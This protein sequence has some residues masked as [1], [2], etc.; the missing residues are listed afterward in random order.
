M[1]KRIDIPIRTTGSGKTRRDLK[2]VDRSIDNLST[3]VKGLA[4]AFISVQ[5]LNF[6]KNIAEQGERINTAVIALDNLTGSAEESAKFITKMGEAVRGT[7]TDLDLAIFASKALTLGFAATAT[8]AAELT[9]TAILLG[10]AM[11]KDAI[12]SLD[13]FTQLLAN[14]SIMVMDNLGISVAKYNALLKKFRDETGGAATEQAKLNAILEIA[15]EATEKQKNLLDT[16]DYA[17][18]TVAIKNLADSFSTKFIESISGSLIVITDFIEEITKVTDS[19]YRFGKAALLI[20]SILFVG[21]GLILGFKLLTVGLVKTVRWGGLVITIFKGWA[22][23]LKRVITGKFTLV[24]WVE[25][26]AKGISGLSKRVPFLTKALGFLG[27][28]FLTMGKSA[29]SAS[30]AL[31]DLIKSTEKYA[32]AT[33][34]FSKLTKEE[35][36]DQL[37]LAASIVR[38]SRVRLEVSHKL[39]AAALGTENFAKALELLGKSSKNLG[40]AEERLKALMLI[41]DANKAAEIKKVTESLKDFVTW[42]AK[43][44][45]S[46]LDA[47]PDISERMAETEETIRGL[48]EGMA[49]AATEAQA[50]W[51]AFFSTIQGGLKDIASTF[52]SIQINISDGASAFEVAWK[53]AINNIIATI[54]ANAAIF[55]LAAVFMPG[56]VVTTGI[57]SIITGLLTGFKFAAHGMNEIVTKPTLIVAGEAG[58]EHVKITPNT[59]SAPSA[60]GNTF[61]IQLQAPVPEDYVR[62]ELIPVLERIQASS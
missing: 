6:F 33:K 11:N 50:P 27:L 25:L 32:V 1:A 18:L 23:A 44:L 45:S 2:G 60:Q 8:E 47:L 34:D 21:K 61:I 22:D 13:T 16:K 37:K 55:A 56:A 36:A 12:T 10:A 19:I 31:K 5:A 51:M 4:A 62:N 30:E 3:T 7:V 26:V 17:R 41:F 49:L 38:V 15:A 42:Y 24:K 43:L 57:G 28:S 46:R 20:A 48:R 58:P 9:R 40:E 54:V 53:S 39:A 29:E 14:K 35:L 59:V 52:T